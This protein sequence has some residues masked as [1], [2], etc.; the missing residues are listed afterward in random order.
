MSSKSKPNTLTTVT[1]SVQENTNKPISRLT[2]V[3]SKSF[4]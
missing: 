3:Y 4:N 1:T 2:L